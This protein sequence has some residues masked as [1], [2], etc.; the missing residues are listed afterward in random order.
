MNSIQTTIIESIGEAPINVM[1][2]EL[3]E[4]RIDYLEHIFVSAGKRRRY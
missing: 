2:A 3:Q 4:Y 1:E